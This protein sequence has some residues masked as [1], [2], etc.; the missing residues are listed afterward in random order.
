MERT[1]MERLADAVE[2]YVSTRTPVA[3]I[4]EQHKVS[5]RDLYDEL[6][7]GGAQLRGTDNWTHR[8]ALTEEEGKKYFAMMVNDGVSVYKLSKLLG[9]ERSTIQRGIL[10]YV[11]EAAQRGEDVREWL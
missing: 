9:M 3:E 8:I 4:L 11:V 10:H 5:S 7:I 6:H 2:M 1:K